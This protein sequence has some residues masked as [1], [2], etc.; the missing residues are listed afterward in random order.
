MMQRLVADHQVRPKAGEKRLTLYGVDNLYPR[1]QGAV[2]GAPA[3]ALPQAE[4]EILAV[5]IAPG[6]FISTRLICTAYDRRGCRIG[7]GGRLGGLAGVGWH[8]HVHGFTEPAADCAGRRHGI[9][10]RKF[11]DARAV[12]LDR[13][14]DVPASRGLAIVSPRRSPSGVVGA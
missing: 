4:R 9:L 11:G 8:V 2:T 12:R 6:V 13:R 1:R 5:A 3:T 10:F 14:A 7:A